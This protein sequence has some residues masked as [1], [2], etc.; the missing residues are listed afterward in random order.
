MRVILKPGGLA[1]IA[2]AFVLLATVA[3]MRR[4]SRSGAT[5]NAETGKTASKPAS[6]KAFD[7]G[8]TSSDSNSKSGSSIIVPTDRQWSLVTQPPAEAQKSLFVTDDVPSNPGMH[9]LHL[10]VTAVDSG[11]YWSAQLV[12][13][14]PAS[15]PA[16]RSMV[17]RFWGRSKANTPV[18]IVFEE[19]NSP[20]A[21]ELSKQ[22][23]LT[24]DWKRYE[25][26]FR[27]SKDHTDV[28]ANFC[29]K[30]GIQP[31][32]LEVA[33]VHLDDLGAAR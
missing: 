33:D 10:T 28:H 12:K 18:Y 7:S 6:P 21:A 5:G 19:G 32:E 23:S 8:A 3:L 14:V 13:S 1:L 4:D 9:A 11:K 25:L 31:G 27:T 22:V 15:V 29:L 24:P 2:I 17:A 16:G 20:H 30:A 26:P